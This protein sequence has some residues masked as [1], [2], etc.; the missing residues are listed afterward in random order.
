MTTRIAEQA[1]STT[2]NAQPSGADDKASTTINAQP[3]GADDKGG[4]RPGRT[5]PPVYETTTVAVPNRSITVIAVTE[6]PA[7]PLPTVSLPSSPAA[8]AARRDYS[9]AAVDSDGVDGVG[10]LVAGQ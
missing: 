1:A 4:H 6:H 7:S 10:L 9:V 2:I 5:P 8:V 3:S